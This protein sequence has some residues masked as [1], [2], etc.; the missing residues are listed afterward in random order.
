MIHCG[1]LYIEPNDNDGG[2][3]MMI[4]VEQGGNVHSIKYSPYNLVMEMIQVNVTAIDNLTIEG[5]DRL[6][7]WLDG[8]G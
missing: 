5:K 2:T 1:C 4:L 8:W 3:M 6:V 7:G